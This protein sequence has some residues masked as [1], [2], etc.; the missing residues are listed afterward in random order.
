ME[1]RT[2]HTGELL[3]IFVAWNES[4]TTCV[5]WSKAGTKIVEL[6]RRSWRSLCAE[7]HSRVTLKLARLE[8]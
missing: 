8:P 1:P 7:A 3:E 2:Q 5:E 6:S 4:I